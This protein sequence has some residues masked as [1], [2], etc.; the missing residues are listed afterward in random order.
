MKI[1][2]GA[3]HRGFELKEKLKTQLS[4]DHEIIDCGTD[5]TEACDYPDIARAVAERVS[6]HEADRGVLIC[7]SGIGM[8]MAA[9]KV[10]GI[11]AGVCHNA[12]TA[13]LSREHNDTNVLVVGSGEVSDT[14]DEIVDI[15]LKT[16]FEGGRHKRRVEKIMNIE[17]EKKE[18]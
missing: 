13:Q 11:R 5:S 18:D 10:S 9:N 8:A 7:W 2:I 17:K 1:A 4:K 12:R 6:R 14:V 15:W 3:D 16:A